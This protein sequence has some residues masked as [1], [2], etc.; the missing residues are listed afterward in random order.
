MNLKH[1][2]IAFW[3]GEGYSSERLKKSLSRFGPVDAVKLFVPF[4]YEGNSFDSLKD[5]YNCE[6]VYSDIRDLE[7]LLDLLVSTIDLENQEDA[8]EIC[9]NI[10][11]ANPIQMYAANTISIYRN[12]PVSYY[13]SDTDKGTLQG[14]LGSG[15]MYLTDNMKQCLRALN[16]KPEGLDKKIIKIYDN[17]KLLQR[18]GRDKCIKDLAEENLVE[19]YNK[20]DTGTRGRP[21]VYCKLTD[22]G[23]LYVRLVLGG[24]E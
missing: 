3:G 4:G 2:Q 24:S 16:G 8:C 21:P 13:T 18:N 10:S 11:S 12:I 5:F 6:Y 15:K 7:K 22:R 23:R 19:T 9:F 14:E 1:V 17:G 20:S